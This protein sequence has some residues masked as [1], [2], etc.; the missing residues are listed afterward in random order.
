MKH[1]NKRSG[2]SPAALGSLL[3]TAG[4]ALLAGLP[5][6]TMAEELENWDFDAAMLL[7][8]ESDNRVKVVEPVI[9]ATRNYDSETTLNLKL[10]LDSLSGASPNGALPSYDA[11]TFTSPSGESSYTVPGSAQTTTSPSGVV[12]TLSPGLPLDPNFRDSRVTFSAQ[13]SAPIGRTWAYSVGG[14]GSTEG[15]YKS[16]GANGSVSRYFNQKNTTVTVGS[17]LAS[18]TVEPTGGIPVGLALMPVWGSASFAADFDATHGA[19]E[20]DKSVTDLLFGITQVINRRTLMQF[21]YSIST[22][23][24][25]LTDPYK[26]ISVLDGTGAVQAYIYEQ[27]PESRQKQALFWQTKYQRKNGSIIDA[28]YRYM[29]DDWGINSHTVDL[30]YRFELG[31]AGNYLEP[32]VRFY[33]QSAADFYQPY[34]TVEQYNAGPDALSADYRLGAM[35]TLTLGVRYTKVLDSGNELYARAAFYNQTANG[36]PGSAVQVASSQLPQT[37]AI[38]L[39]TGYKF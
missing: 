38:M 11:Q 9:S 14:Y 20:S 6:Q 34:V 26:I 5:N 36:K 35:N 3:A 29:L 8:S 2:A 16:L 12:S 31:E 39:I 4:C 25:Y 28:S 7:Y 13:W 32:Q 18:D 22:S 27:R 23:N 1:D 37:R 15:D 21:N 33:T 24:G 17:A 30:K 19:A 10:V